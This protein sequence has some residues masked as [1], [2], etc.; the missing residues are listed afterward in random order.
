MYN[1]HHFWNFSGTK[2]RW[3]FVPFGVTND[4]FVHENLVLSCHGSLPIY[5]TNPFTY[6]FRYCGSFST[7]IIVPFG[8][9]NMGFKDLGQRH[10]PIFIFIFIFSYQWYQILKV[11][12]NKPF[13]YTLLCLIVGGK[14]DTW[15]HFIMTPPF[16]IF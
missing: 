2:E 13:M 9:Q 6:H 1:F 8:S 11:Y 12:C 7:M 16:Y 10:T 5:C 3:C 4:F 15:F 14:F